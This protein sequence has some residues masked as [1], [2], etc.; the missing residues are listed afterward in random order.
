MVVTLAAIHRVAET[1]NILT[2]LGYLPEGVQLQSNRLIPLPTGPLRLTPENPIFILWAE[3][4]DR[5]SFPPY[6]H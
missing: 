4:H 3:S 6:W 1:A 5:G 2:D